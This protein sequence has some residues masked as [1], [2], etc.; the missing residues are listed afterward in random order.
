MISLRQRLRDLRK[1]PEGQ[2]RQQLAAFADQQVDGDKVITPPRYV[3]AEP[4]PMGCPKRADVKARMQAAEDAAEAL[5]QIQQREIERAQEQ[6][7][8]P[9]VRTLRPRSV[10]S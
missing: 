9:K 10:K 6:A 8:S 3:Y 5:W 2:L 1:K 7:R 4:D